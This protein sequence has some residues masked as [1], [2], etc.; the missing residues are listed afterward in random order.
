MSKHLGQGAEDEADFLLS[1]PQAPMSSLQRLEDP[2]RVNKVTAQWL[3]EW[4][5][6]GPGSRAG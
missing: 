1:L 6:S 4:Q 3:G 2:E 5:D